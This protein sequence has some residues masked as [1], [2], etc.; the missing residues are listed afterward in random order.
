MIVGETTGIS[1]FFNSVLYNYFADILTI[2]FLALCSE[3]TFPSVFYYYVLFTLTNGGSYHSYLKLPC[4]P[5]VC[6]KC[7]FH[8]DVDVMMI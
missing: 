3:K 4:I 8:I 5:H 1:I 2:N 6:Q 7:S